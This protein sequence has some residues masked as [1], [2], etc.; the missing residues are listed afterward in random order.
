LKQEFHELLSTFAFSFNLRRYLEGD[1]DYAR[2]MEAPYRL[3][4]SQAEAVMELELPFWSGPVP[5]D[6]LLIEWD[7]IS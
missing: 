6:C 5:S 3:D 4:E 2:C 1:P 7:G